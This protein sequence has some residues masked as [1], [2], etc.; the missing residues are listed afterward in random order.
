MGLQEALE[1]KG[2][3]KI[4]Q[5]V[6]KILILNSIILSYGGIPL[7]YAVDEIGTLNDYSFTKDHDHKNGSR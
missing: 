7:I 3:T 2:T 6:S 5:A 4:E 1:Q